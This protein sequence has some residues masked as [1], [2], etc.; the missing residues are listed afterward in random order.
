VTATVAVATYAPE[1]ERTTGQDGAPRVLVLAG[2]SE[3]SALARRLATSDTVSV[4]SSF[5]GR[6]T[7]LSLPPGHVRIGGF[8]GIEGLV[9]YLCTES[10]R[11]VI[12]ATHPFTA[13]MPWH[14]EAACRAAHVER[15]RLL[16]DEWQRQPGDDWHL[17]ANLD[18]AAERLEAMGARRVFLTTGRQELSPFVRVPETTFL[19]RAIE[20]PDPMPLARAEVVL[21][22]GPF[23][24]EDELA[25]MA[26]YRID[27]LVT[28]NSGGGAAAAKL[29]AAR[30]LGIPVVMVT[31]PASPQGD[32]VATVGQALD[33]VAAALGLPSLLD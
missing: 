27:A 2:S 15:V 7:D 4:V 28:K 33:W 13:V 25:L 14:A 20:P 24:L 23:R 11:A 10:I 17:V 1:M 22:R 8:G 16:R 9:T 12:D 18:A 30:Q 26:R 21:S 5:A 32:T 31:R 19:V 29:D 3:A 6:V